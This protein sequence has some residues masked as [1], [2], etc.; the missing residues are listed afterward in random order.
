M[1]VDDKWTPID[2]NQGQRWRNKEELGL[3]LGGFGGRVKEDRR[4]RKGYL[5]IP[6]QKGVVAEVPMD[7]AEKVLAFGFP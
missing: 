7:F 4:R 5:V 3:Y 1:R 6:L 2:I